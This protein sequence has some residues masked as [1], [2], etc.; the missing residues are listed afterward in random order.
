MHNLYGKEM[1]TLLQERNAALRNNAAF[2]KEALRPADYRATGYSIG[3]ER[4]AW[5]ALFDPLTPLAM[6]DK[7]ASTFREE[8]TECA[9]QRKFSPPF[10]DTRVLPPKGT[11]VAT[12]MV[13]GYLYGK[14]AFA[15]LHND[16]ISD[17]FVLMSYSSGRR[18]GKYFSDGVTNMS[19][20]IYITAR[21]LKFLEEC[22][23]SPI[24]LVDE[25]KD[26]GLT[27]ST[28]GNSL[29]CQLSHSRQIYELYSTRGIGKWDGKVYSDEVRNLIE[30]VPIIT[31]R[32][33]KLL[34]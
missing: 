6:K 28:I 5:V 1:T 11:I 13:G 2:L 20:A 30:N 17:S 33:N 34:D 3:H 29:K 10:F 24:L 4:F 7:I 32:Q 16:S 18:Q 14:E 31:E 12:V 25:C 9:T 23:D 21:D 19:G 22:P 8:F 15:R 26:T 27:L